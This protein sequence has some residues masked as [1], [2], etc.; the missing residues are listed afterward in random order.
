MA[1]VKSRSRPIFDR[2]TSTKALNESEVQDESRN[3][4]PEEASRTGEWLAV[5][6]ASGETARDVNLHISEELY[7][8]IL[9]VARSW[10]KI[11][12]ADDAK[13][14]VAKLY[15]WGQGF[16]GGRLSIILS[17]ADKLRDTILSLLQEIGLLLCQGKWNYVA[18]C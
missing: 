2:I 3:V 11:N 13:D 1:R 14:V 17:Q 7:L 12:R 6:L 4:A 8:T 18:S 5:D 10:S 16:S 9:G 15:I